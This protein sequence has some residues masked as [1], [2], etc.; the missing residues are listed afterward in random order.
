M[1]F[2]E[3]Q[4]RAISGAW[5]FKCNLIN[6]INVENCPFLSLEIFFTA[7]DSITRPHHP[8]DFVMNNR[9]KKKKEGS[10]GVKKKLF[11]MH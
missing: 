9:R 11:Q 8:F 2:N 6:S 5:N 4:S 3:M 1:T 7:F 10:D